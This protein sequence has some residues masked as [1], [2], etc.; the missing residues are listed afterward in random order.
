MVGLAS[1]ELKEISVI[2]LVQGWKKE[3]NVLPPCPFFIWAKSAS[4]HSYNVIVVYPGMIIY[5]L[6]T[7]GRH[8]ELKIQVF[9]SDI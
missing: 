4:T 1:E 7:L 2:Y 3:E 8:V 6:A 9:P 5:G